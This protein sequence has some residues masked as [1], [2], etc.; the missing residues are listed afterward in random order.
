MVVREVDG[1]NPQ[2]WPDSSKANPLALKVSIVCC[3][4]RHW[5]CFRIGND[6]ELVSSSIVATDVE[7]N[8]IT[9]LR[10][11]SPTICQIDRTSPYDVLI[12]LLH[13]KEGRTCSNGHRPGCIS[14]DPVNHLLRARQ[15]GILSAVEFH[16]YIGEVIVG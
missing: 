9:C 12:F 6:W 10:R 11:D 15:I 2:L 3:Q 1:K 5:A 8:E 16:W 13:A 4:F 14:H 7:P